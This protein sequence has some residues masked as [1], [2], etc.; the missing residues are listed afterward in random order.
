MEPDNVV[1]AV[2]LFYWLAMIRPSGAGWSSPAW[3]R[4]PCEH[5]RRSWTGSSCSSVQT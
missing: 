5:R 3:K 4:R 2:S 1:Q